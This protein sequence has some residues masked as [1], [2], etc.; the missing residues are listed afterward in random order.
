MTKT[1]IYMQQALTL[2]R[3]A[4]GRTAPNPAVGAVIVRNDRVV[5][6]GF[7]PRAG[8][9]H[10][11]I[12]ALR[13]A[14][15][16]ATGA[17][18]YVTLEPCSHQGRTGPC[19]DALITAGVKRVFVGTIDPNPQVAGRG[20]KRLQEA[21]IDGQVGV[22]E[23]E[24]RALIAP[25]SWHIR[26]GMPYT[27]YKAAMTLDGQMATR[28][29]DSRWV[30]GEESRQRVHRLRDQVD[31]IMVGV[32]TV[33]ADNPQ[34]STRLPQGGR[35]P[36]RVVVDS[37]LRIPLDSRIVNLQSTAPTLIATTDRAPADKMRRLSAL[38]CEVL[39][40]PE[41]KGRVSLIELWQR[42]GQR[43]IQHLLLEGGR[44]LAAAALQS[45][46]INRLQVYIA[47]K[48]VGG[49][50]LSGLFSGPGCALMKDALAV[51][52]LRVEQVGSDL[53]L[54]AEVNICLQ[55]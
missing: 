9:P 27:L 52:D 48:L 55:D 45:G 28:R 4:L 7:H 42:L 29:G 36:L 5:G 13:D 32:D 14:V 18:I 26:T 51:S 38:G 10:A 6:E 19:A 24:C 15:D 11:E 20:I 33:L 35:D 49:T 44:T 47:P 22:C 23:A 16:E 41:V 43:D 39:L 25:F 12:F 3:R 2:A 17:D 53:L 30:S 8:E 50:G 40:L 34:L 1:Q 46:L 54:S 21:G 31:A 37:Q